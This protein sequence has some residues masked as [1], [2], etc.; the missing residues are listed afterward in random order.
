MAKDSTAMLVEVRIFI[1]PEMEL[2]ETALSP[3]VPRVGEFFNSCGE[4]MEVTSVE[5]HAEKHRLY[6][7]VYVRDDSDGS[8]E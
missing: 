7:H 6:A 8:E 2:I 4:S 3:C 1:A 5:W